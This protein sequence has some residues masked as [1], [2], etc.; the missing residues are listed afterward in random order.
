M[1]LTSGIQATLER[2]PVGDLSVVDVCTVLYAAFPQMW[3]QYNVA[4]EQVDGPV[5]L[6]S[7]PTEHWKAI[8]ETGNFEQRVKLGDG[9]KVTLTIEVTS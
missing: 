3:G 8:Q 5:W 4:I 6:V 2:E 9:T 7:L 1:E